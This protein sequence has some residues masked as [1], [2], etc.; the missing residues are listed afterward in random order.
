MC[1]N[2]NH[3]TLFIFTNSWR[4]WIHQDLV[5]KRDAAIDRRLRRQFS[6]R[7]VLV[8]RQPDHRLHAREMCGRQTAGAQH[9]TSS[10]EPPPSDV[11]I[12][13]RVREGGGTRFRFPRP[14]RRQHSNPPG[15]RQIC[16]RDG[17]F[18]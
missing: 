1:H 10:G 14:S 9:Q 15:N 6:V 12:T 5:E 3:K 8:P 13:S 7:G 16:I 18:N 2:T 11:C 4:G 17:A